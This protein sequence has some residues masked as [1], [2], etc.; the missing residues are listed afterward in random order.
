MPVYLL[1]TR[2]DHI[3]P[4]QSAYLSTRLLSGEARFVLGASGH[5]AGVINPVSKNKRSY[6]V[7]ADVKSDAD[8]WLAGAAGE[9][10]KLVGRLGRL[11]ETVVR[12]TAGTAQT[13]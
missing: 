11:A 8:G 1:A 4:W 12:R 13:G 7:N 10:G 6:W 5:I 9:E 3:V 2:E